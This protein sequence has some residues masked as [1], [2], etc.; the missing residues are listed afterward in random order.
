MLNLIED[1]AFMT[2]NRRSRLPSLVI[3]LTASLVPAA[4]ILTGCAPDNPAISTGSSGKLLY[5]D[6]KGYF[7]QELKRLAAISSVTKATEVN[8]VREERIIA[9]P[10]FEKELAVFINA[11]IN[12]PAWSDKYS[13]DSLFNQD[14]QLAGLVY[15]AVDEKLQIRQISVDFI[16]DQ[17][18][19]LSIQSAMHSSIAD[20]RQQLNYDP[21]A[22]YSIESYQ[23]IPFLSQENA[24]LVT[25]RFDQ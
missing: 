21:E 18:R 2:H 1:E 16:D 19:K 8:G 11:D 10:D 12:K 4:A 22:G 20:S 17:V 24:F 6:I 23:R 25:V 13:V 15:A 5:F 7:R 9:A 3:F 14:R